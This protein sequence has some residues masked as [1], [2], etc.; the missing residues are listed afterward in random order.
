MRVEEE[1][2]APRA[3]VAVPVVSAFGRVDLWVRPQVADAL[4]VD[5]DQ[6]VAG[7]LEREVAERLR[8]RETLIYLLRR[9]K[10]IY[11]TKWELCKVK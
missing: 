3:Q 4:D 10:G 7:L 9:Y 1:G 6:V 2:H 11:C 8:Q 5:D